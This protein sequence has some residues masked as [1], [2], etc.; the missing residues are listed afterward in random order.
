M[1]K[2]LKTGAFTQDIYKISATQ[3]EELDTIRV[4]ADGRVFAYA[5]A[6]STALAVAKLNQSVAPLSTSNKETVAANAAV[7]ATVLSVTFGT[8][9]TANYYKDGWIYDCIAGDLY[10]VK[11][12]AAGTTGV[13]VYLKEPLRIAWTAASSKATAI[14]NRQNGV[15][16]CPYA[17]LTGGTAGIAPVAVTANYYFWNQVK[18]PAV[19]LVDGTWAIGEELAPSNAVAGAAEPMVHA[20]TW[21]TTVG[22]VLS[23][24]ANT[25]YGLINLAIPGY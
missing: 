20:T 23:V 10:R 12:H 3:L 19:C 16:I 21:D 15:I 17:A 1:S 6:G 18:G 14:A 25:E 9:V 22:S 2:S 8:A 11:E 13:Q 7:G 5:Y 24:D 4:L